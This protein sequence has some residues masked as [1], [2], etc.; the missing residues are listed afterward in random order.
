MALVSLAVVGKRNEPLYIREYTSESIVYPA[1]DG[2]AEIGLTLEGLMSIDGDD[3]NVAPGTESCSLRHQFILHS[4][5][6]RLEEL[7]AGNR[8]RAPG[9]VGSD[10][11]WVGMLCPVDELKVYGYLTTTKIKFL[12]AVED[13]FPP[14]Q[15]QQLH[16]RE[17][18]IK[19]LFANIHTLYVEYMLNPFTNIESSI[20]SRRFEEGVKSFVDAFNSSGL[21]VA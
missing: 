3:M 1:G 9:S 2:L 20:E 19:S 12:V 8:W 6:D 21:S 17:N 15:K 4:A 5:L 11:M 16:A 7:T 10:A 14:D 18:E 13:I